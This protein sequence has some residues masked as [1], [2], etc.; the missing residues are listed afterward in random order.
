M[1]I[2]DRHLFMSFVAAY[3]ICF[4]S[5]VGLYVI[6][7]LFA[8]A[9]EFFEDHAGTL[10]FLRR[11]AKFYF[12]HSFEYFARLSPVITMISAMTTL[13]NLH[14]H[15]EIVALLAA[16]IPT[17]RAL[18]PI[19]GG[20]LV[21]IGLGIANRE[22]V[23]PAYSEVLQRLHEDIEAD[24][25]LLPSM[26]IDKD[27]VLFRADHA[28]REEK[29][30]ENVNVTFPVEI[31]GILQE[32][33]CIKAYHRPDPDT[34]E[35]GWL[36]VDGDAP[37]DTSMARG[38]VRQLPDG[39]LFVRTNVTFED[40]IRRPNWKSYASTGEL[41][42]LLQREEIKDPQDVRVLIHSRLMDPA[43]HFLL[44]LIGLPFV[45]QWERKNV[46]AGIAVAM[47]LCGAFFV[48]GSMA[49]YFASH[50]YIDAML[51]AW[52]PLLVFGPLAM[53]LFPRI[54]T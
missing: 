9:D 24:H 3:V 31:T 21:V 52:T 30:L 45:L 14:R 49:S 51:A 40:M 12:V 35:P 13:A 54:G 7:D 16:G 11:V 6:I 48:T 47:A 38:K 33:H 32:V 34:G 29:R 10:V 4:V 28:H 53:A 44:V 5:L 19:L 39:K 8:N 27:Q 46:F 18:F 42:T 41:V 2:M 26:C 37:I 20:T 36:L 15:N 43:L 50:G 1:K 25:V 17:R 22:F 23:L